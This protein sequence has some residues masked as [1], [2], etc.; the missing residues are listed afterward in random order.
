MLQGAQMMVDLSHWDF[1]E[2]FSPYDTAALI[3]GL[4]P[5][6]SENDQW[7][8]RVVEERMELHYRAALD[9]AEHDSMM[10]P[11]LEDNTTFKE[12]HTPLF[13]TELA[14][15][16][17]GYWDGE[18]EIFLRN[19]LADKKCSRFDNQMFSRKEIVK[20]LDAIGMES[21]YK[22]D[23]TSNPLKSKGARWPWGNHHTELLGHLEAAAKRFWT[24]YDPADSHTANTNDTVSKWLQTERKVSRTMADAIASIL[25]AD[26]LR[27][28]PRK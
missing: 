24:A 13:S 20:W 3:L 19:W 4:E 17:T 10:V 7:R 5:R 26:G 23:S 1:A 15:L 8:V 18:D 25:R 16:L 22:F 27:P 28:G 11:F 21:I 14:D 6:E 12:K 2:Q 9:R